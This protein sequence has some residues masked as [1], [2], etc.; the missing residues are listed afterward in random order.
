MAF[1][2]AIKATDPLPDEYK[3]MEF[4]SCDFCGAEYVIVHH[5]KTLDQDRAVIQAEHIELTLAA[6]H[7]DEGFKEHPATYE[8]LDRT[9]HL[10]L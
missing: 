6:E 1:A 2:K 10:K 8:P 5:E 9:E 3:V 7:V 4:A